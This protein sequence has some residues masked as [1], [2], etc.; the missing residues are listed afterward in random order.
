MYTQE[1]LQKYVGKKIIAS[2]S[3]NENYEGSEN[4]IC[5]VFPQCYLDNGQWQIVPKEDFLTFGSIVVHL[6]EKQNAKD[7][8]NEKGKLVIIKI[9][10]A[11]EN[12]H[13][14]PKSDKLGRYSYHM[15]FS[16]RWGRDKSQIWIESFS[17]R[18]NF[19]QY[20]PANRP[21][22]EL[23]RLKLLQYPA[24]IY[25]SEILVLCDGYYYGPF[26]Y[27][28]K[29]DSYV[30]IRMKEEKGLFKYVHKYD[31]DSIESERYDIQDANKNIICSMVNVKDVAAIDTYSK[32]DWLN[33]N[34]LINFF[35]DTLNVCQFPEEQVELFRNFLQ[36]KGANI[37]EDRQKRLNDIINKAIATKDFARSMVQFI[38]KDDNLKDEFMKV[39]PDDGVYI[40]NNISY[41]KL[42][43]DNEILTNTNEQLL[44]ENDNLKNKLANYSSDIKSKSLQEEINKLKEENN[45]LINLHED[46][47]KLE[48]IK[49]KL[50]TETTLLQ[51]DYNE[52]QHKLDI[53]KSSIKTSVLE[54]R[55]EAQIISKQID[56]KLLKDVLDTI[57]STET[58]KKIGNF[59]KR[60]LVDLS[61][62][63]IIDRVIKYF[64]SV[65]RPITHNEV[66][67][68]LICISQGFITT[69]AGEPGTGKTS[70]CNILSRALG[71]S[72]TD[73][74]NRFAEISV[75][76]GWNSIK[77]FIGY[78]NPLTSRMEPSNVEAF[79]AL[80]VLDKENDAN[81]SYAPYIIL[82]DEANLS[83]VEHYWANFLRLC[84]AN[85][86][87]THKLNLGGSLN[88][89]IP[90]HL[91]FLAT[92]NF[93][94]TTEELS[95]RFLDRSWIITLKSN[96]HMSIKPSVDVPQEDSIVSFESL[97]KAF[98]SQEE[99]LEQSDIYYQNNEKWKKIQSIFADNHKAIMPRNLI[100]VNKYI[101][102]ACKYMEQQSD[103]RYIPLDYAISQKILPL[104]NGAGET[105]RQL[106]DR[107][108]DET[109]ELTQTYEHLERIKRL[110][111]QNM[112]FYQFFAK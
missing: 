41:K 50:E 90:Q 18:Y 61:A 106:I 54:L 69:F 48:N 73:D 80:N 63:Q 104:I 17:E 65:G 110:A 81:E 43:Y 76:R 88:Y 14:F 6:V 92:V 27:E 77:D 75:E 79:N 64:Y 82:L 35:I 16:S 45:R 40:Q 62:E 68:Y 4:T 33:D 103:N 94:H 49:E 98:N 3:F 36:S 42:K 74:N 86:T 44:S 30:T 95:P 20:I 91:R 28:K 39:L 2:L 112:D 47:S 67:N 5:Y 93:D 105:Y 52:Y 89:T 83:P 11:D 25:T 58:V 9:N 70:L 7:F 13:L 32:V 22:N 51:K 96:L 34:E 23:S 78:Y 31:R 60:F 99:T 72:R 87:I 29:Q 15:G 56:T 111:E 66:V 53:I 108:I 46:V 109:N 57:S 59:E 12:S 8:V 38:M 84:D 1:N 10:D 24:P 97:S 101:K 37:T 100:M 21:Y 71:L 55:D 19:Y 85:S 26:S 107:L 102:I